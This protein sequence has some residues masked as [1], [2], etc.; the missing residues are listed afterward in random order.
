[1]LEAQ[2]DAC[3]NIYGIFDQLKPI[4]TNELS[5]RIKEFLCQES[6]SKHEYYSIVAE[7]KSFKEL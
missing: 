7:I 3:S 5:I 1:V 6:K 2:Y 4:L